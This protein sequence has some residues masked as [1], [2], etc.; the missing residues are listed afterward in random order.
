MS[1][2]K[3]PNADD[4]VS[5][6]KKGAK[7]PFMWCSFK[8]CRC[9]EPTGEV[10]P[11]YYDEVELIEPHTTCANS[12]IFGNYYITLTDAD[13]QAMKDGKIGAILHE[14]YNVFIKYVGG[15]VDG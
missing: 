4:R 9:E 11:N 3:C 8:R 13:I 15:E 5:R 14:E 1:D 6:S 10:S 12:S 2:L 7:N